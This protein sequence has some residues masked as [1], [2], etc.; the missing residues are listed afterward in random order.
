MSDAV[1]IFGIRH[2]GPGSARSLVRAMEQLRPDCLLIEGPP[3][4]QDLIA[5]AANERLEPPVALLVYV[6]D[7]PKRA[8]FYP[9]AVFSPEWQAMRFGLSRGLPVRFMDL[10]QWHRLLPE[11]TAESADD[12]AAVST[13]SGE[14]PPDP[15]MA[16]DEQLRTDPLDHLARAAGFGDGERWWDFMIESRQ[17]GDAEIFAAVREAM[18]VLREKVESPFQED[19]LRREAYMRR[20]IREAVKEGFERIAVVCGAWHAPALADVNAAGAVKR[21]TELLKGLKKVKTE[22]AW[23]P[24]TY[25]RLAFASGYGAGVASPEWYHLL[26]EQDEPIPARWLTRV[27]RLMRDEDLDTSSAHVIEAVRLAEALAA[28]R[29]RPLPGLE[30]LEEAALSVICGGQEAPLALIRRKLVLGERMGSVPEDAPAPPLQRD[31]AKQQKALRLPP[32]ASQEEHDFDLRKPMDLH[33]SHLLHRLAL[34]GI[35]WGEVQRDRRTGTGTFHEFWTLQWRPELAV[36]VVGATRWGNTVE[37]AAAVYAAHAA[38]EAPTLRALTLLLDHAIL[39]DLPGAVRAIVDRLQERSATAGDVPQLMAAVPALAQVLRY[40]NVRQTDTQ[41]VEGVFDGVVAR[42]CIG[43]RPACTSLDDDA[44]AEMYGLIQDVNH[45]LQLVQNESHLE[46]WCGALGSVS[47]Q[48]NAHGLVV[49]RA[50]RLLQD[51]GSLSTAETARRMSRA[52][53]RAVPANAAAAWIEGFLRGS[54]LILIHDEGL[55]AVLDEWVTQLREEHF[56]EVVPLL[57]RTFA[58][59]PPP[60]RRQ[61]GERV[62]RGSQ[63]VA[64]AGVVAGFDSERAARV[65]PILRLIMEGGS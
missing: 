54:G 57:R 48:E 61:M 2:H 55:W 42:V 1:H 14:L 27:A 60:E 47:E 21:D 4:G 59:F 28:M 5:L 51:G 41:M 39:A 24:W 46:A 7:D 37:E 45:A 35:G 19:D 23:A 32:K 44:A 62:R 11:E 49:G 30:E 26:W 29:G 53:S 64:A 12:P 58:T 6:P 63:G 17:H 56:V 50:T 34:L 52:L 65:L 33:R 22:A 18:A 15:I 10:P 3:D 25:D 8:V 43:L 38:S 36:E 16:E 9:Y 31:L 40:G 20:M 13:E